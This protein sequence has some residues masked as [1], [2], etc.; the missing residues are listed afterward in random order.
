MRLT[1]L[2]HFIGRG[3]STGFFLQLHDFFRS[4]GHEVNLVVGHDAPD[5]MANEYTVVPAGQ[6]WRERMRAYV[7]TIEATRPDAVY[8][9]C[10]QEEFE[11]LRFLRCARA[12][13][14]GCIEQ[15]EYADLPLW[16]RQLEPYNELRTTH[17]PDLL[18]CVKGSGAYPIQL[19][20]CPHRLP[21]VFLKAPD[22]GAWPSKS[23]NGRVN[24]CYLSR[25]EKYQKRSHWLP[26]IM[27]RCERA[28][29]QLHWH[30]YGTGPAEADVRAGVLRA[31]L[32]ES[33]TFHGWKEPEQLAQELGQHDLF[34]LCSRWEGLPAAMVE[35]MLCGLACVVPNF[36][37]GMTFMVKDGGGWL[38]EATSPK[39]S[40]EA[41]LNAVSDR[42][43]LQRKRQEAQTIARALHARDVI[44][45]HLRHVE[46]L[47]KNLKFNGHVAPLET[48]QP[49]KLVTTPV[50]MK[51]AIVSGW[52]RIF[53]GAAARPV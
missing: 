13:H 6:G 42:A 27:E 47:L 4:C 39:A 38:F 44:D 19:A 50:R 12:L 20:Y 29:G 5:P 16:H 48:S 2:S 25:L 34:F 40:A 8:T 30:L 7:R 36:P 9:I 22:L 23:R 52:N 21:E 1:L 26:E 17:T 45:G 51:R 11:V 3:G 43:A 31:G 28:G 14:C 32:A 24:V 41:L 49:M 15:H 37:A 53:P 10:G 35:A 18:D 33:V 46:D